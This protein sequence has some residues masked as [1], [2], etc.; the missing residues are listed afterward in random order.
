MEG[1]PT[2]FEKFYGYWKDDEPVVYWG[3]QNPWR[4][5]QL[6]TLASHRGQNSTVIPS[7]SKGT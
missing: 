4:I 7:F 5:D 6:G 3:F 2:F 1:I